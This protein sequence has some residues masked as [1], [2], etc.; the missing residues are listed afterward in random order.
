MTHGITQEDLQRLAPDLLEYY[1]S[2][3][4]LYSTKSNSFHPG[5][6]NGGITHRFLF[7]RISVVIVVSQ[8]PIFC[9]RVMISCSFL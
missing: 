6:V 4:E 7:A 8:R 3:L 5:R 9:S 2:H 1:E